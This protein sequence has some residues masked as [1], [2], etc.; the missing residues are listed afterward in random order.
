MGET[1]EVSGSQKKEERG[2]TKKLLEKEEVK[3]T[4]ELVPSEEVAVVECSA[5]RRWRMPQ[6]CSPLNDVNAVVVLSGKNSAI[7]GC[8]VCMCA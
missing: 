7:G 1:A 6:L 3:D 8:L 4:D 5:Y 2:D